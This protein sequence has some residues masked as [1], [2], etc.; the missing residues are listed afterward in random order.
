MKHAATNRVAAIVPNAATAAIAAEA[1][2][3]VAAV[4]ATAVAADATGTARARAATTVTA[5]RPKAARRAAN[6]PSVQIVR[7]AA[8][9]LSVP[10]AAGIVTARESRRAMRSRDRGMLQRSRSKRV[11]R[12]A[13][14]S[15]RRSGSAIANVKSSVAANAMLSANPPQR[16]VPCP[17]P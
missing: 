2:G 14:P 12:S 8:N 15:A 16:L 6:V 1:T 7:S 13:T 4:I 10:I 11:T 9:A 5:N 3:I 17:V